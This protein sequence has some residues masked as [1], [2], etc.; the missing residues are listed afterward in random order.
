MGKQGKGQLERPISR[1]Y[2]YCSVIIAVALLVI[3]AL[4]IYDQYQQQRESYLQR[5]NNLAIRTAH[6]VDARIDSTV[7]L[8]GAV[9]LGVENELGRGLEPEINS[10]LE[11]IFKYYPR[12]ENLF[13]ADRNGRVLHSSNLNVPP[14]NIAD[15]DFFKEVLSGRELVISP[16]IT[17][18]V[19][20]RPVVAIVLP[21]G[22]ENGGGVIGAIIALDD[23]ASELDALNNS[24]DQ[25]VLVLDV[26]GRVLFGASPDNDDMAGLLTLKPWTANQSTGVHTLE[27]GEIVLFGYS[28]VPA[29][30][31]GVLVTKPFQA[32]NLEVARSIDL[33]LVLLVFVFL[34]MLLNSLLTIQ[35]HRNQQ[36]QLAKANQQLQEVAY[37]DS[38]TGIYNHRYFQEM[39]ESRITERQPFTVLLVDINHFRYYND[40]FGLKAGDNL[41]KEMAN[42]VQDLAPP[43]AITFRYG[44]D[45]MALLVPDESQDLVVDIAQNIREAISTGDCLEQE[46]FPW[47]RIT[48]STGIACFPRDGV[49]RDEFIRSLE[50]A[51]HE[52]KDTSGNIKVYFSALQGLRQSLDKSESELYTSIRTLLGVIHAKDQYTLGHTERVVALATS[53]TRHLGLPEEEVQTI[54]YGAYLHDIGKIEIDYFTLNK[55]GPLTAEEWARIQLH[56]KVGAEIIRPIASLEKVIP[57]I[58]HH[59]ERYD[60]TGYPMG[61][62]GEEIPLHARIVAIADSF[63]AMSTRRSY[64][65]PM[66]KADALKE[67]QA[68][69]GTQLDPHLV[70]SFMELDLAKDA[71]S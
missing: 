8:L 60:G 45:Q 31:W 67:L 53:L 32:V 40:S 11:Q 63:D 54:R 41:I 69:A 33:W 47:G 1:Y 42:I 44:A 51:L 59:H 3:V 50:Q 6:L 16:G 12:Y 48:A 61:L 22:D 9:V 30:R 19:T 7:V 64:K 37:I 58:L 66:S 20:G 71:V 29:S 65:G 26:D 34:S 2:T 24:A 55:K 13:I 56:P 52:S 18:K 46:S 62:A 36:Q 70:E 10:L 39:L 38:L 43:E 4:G 23:L 5:L 21:F 27:S 35:R 57:I 25:K 49:T 14:L 17:S 15:R 68:C 28:P